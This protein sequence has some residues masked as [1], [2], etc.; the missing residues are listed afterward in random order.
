MGNKHGK[1][2]AK[3]NLRVLL[4][5]VSASGK[6]TFAKQMKLIHCGGFGPAETDNYESIF[7]TNILGIGRKQTGTKKLT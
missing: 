7:Q 4:M 2:A 5:G 6:S 3:V 1:K